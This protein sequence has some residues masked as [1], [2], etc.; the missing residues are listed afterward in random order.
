MNPNSDLRK[1]ISEGLYSWLKFEE[2]SGRKGLF[3]ERYLALPMAQLLK[4]NI[5]G[6][7]LGESTHPVLKVNGS[8]GRPPQLDFIV[9]DGDI[10]KLVVETKWAATTTV[11][12]SDIVWDCIRLELAA[13]HLKCDAIFVLAG[14][15]KRIDEI[16][17]SKSFNPVRK[18]GKPS[19]LMNLHGRGRTSVNITAKRGQVN[20]QL[21]R[22]LDEYPHV[23]F[24]TTYICG[25]GTQHPTRGSQDS[26]V[27]VV[28]QIRP[29]LNA[30]RHLF[31]TKSRLP[32]QAQN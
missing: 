18:N 5:A 14:T 25:Y 20:K 27:A 3:S 8:T 11:N 16:L 1:V 19:L 17:A 32:Q 28:W 21:L 26:H 10:P 29:E 2:L 7:I 9:K 4:E 12:A 30:K 6:T 15:Q 13:H 23:R 24:A 31:T 22:I